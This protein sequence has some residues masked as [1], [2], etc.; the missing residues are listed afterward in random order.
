MDNAVLA[1]SVKT[2]LSY[3]SVALV[4]VKPTRS[5]ELLVDYG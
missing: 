5:N 4:V 3:G 2:S 1:T